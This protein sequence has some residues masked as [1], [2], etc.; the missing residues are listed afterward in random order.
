MQ[1]SRDTEVVPKGC[2]VYKQNCIVPGGELVTVGKHIGIT[3]RTELLDTGGQCNVG[4]QC[5]C[6]CV[7][8]CAAVD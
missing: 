6:V 1:C 3:Y 2:N 7:C 8:A 4:L 5:V